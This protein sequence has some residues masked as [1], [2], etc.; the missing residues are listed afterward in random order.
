MISRLHPSQCLQ[1]PSNEF[2]KVEYLLEFGQW[3]YANE[4]PLQDVLDQVEWA[5]D[6]LLNM[7][8]EESTLKK[9]G[10]YAVHAVCLALL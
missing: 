2:Q 3:L 7:Q 10:T 9:D 5:V 8:D 6:I 4:F 1:S